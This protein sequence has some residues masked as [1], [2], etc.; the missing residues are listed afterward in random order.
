VFFL[1]AVSVGSSFFAV[2]ARAGD[3]DAAAAQSLFD[4]AKKL[5]SQGAYAEACPKLE[6]SQRLDA[7]SGTLLNLGDCYEH[8]GRT[9]SA[10]GK[11]VE[12][13]EA[14]HAAG[15]V[16]REKVARERA[17]AL[18][19]RLSSVIITVPSGETPG[20]ELKRDGALVD[21]GQWG[22]PIAVDPGSHTV[23]ASA[24]ARIAWETKIFIR[25]AG[26]TVTVVVPTLRE[27]SSTPTPA[28]MADGGTKS[29]V[30]PRPIV[31]DHRP[32][33]APLGL[34]T[35]RIFALVSGG[36]GIGGLAIGTGFGLESKAK[37][38]E[39]AEYCDGA[40]CR[41]QAGVE[42]KRGAIVAGNASTVA[43]A[44]GAAG[45][46]GGAVLWFTAPSPSGATTVQVG[47]D[48]RGATVR[49]TW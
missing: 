43:F 44:L 39:A 18:F 35:Q 24:P 38:D 36:L 11:F 4:H 34:G 16:E 9:A 10:W 49:G 1:I 32:K 20:L 15:K 8:Q 19:P 30:R 23:T 29:E 22:V 14:A 28:P 41:E 45:L 5:M 48:A 40:T 6:E 46:V 33:A 3:G 2:S 17:S 31:M 12:A 13:A 42:L 27:R 37:R 26:E 25:A 47:V 21:K 7:G